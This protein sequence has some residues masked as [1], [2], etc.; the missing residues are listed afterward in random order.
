MSSKISATSSSS[1]LLDPQDIHLGREI[2]RGT[3]GVVLQGTYFGSNVAIKQIASAANALERAQAAKL[4]TNEVKTLSQCRHQNI[5]R[6]VG[7]CVTP[8]ML[9]MDLAS[10][11]TL[12]DLLDR[13]Q[14]EQSS[15]SLTSSLTPLDRLNLVI[16]V[17]NG[18]TMAHSQNILH[19][20]LKP[21]NILIGPDQVPWIADFG[22]AIHMT[23]SVSRGGSS[24]GT[25]GTSQY[26]APELFDDDDDDD[27]D[28]SGSGDGTK[29]SAAALP[30][31]T[32]YQKSADVYSFG[33][34]CW[35]VFTGKVRK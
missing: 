33:M 25:R 20:D 34:L 27:S 24:G 10:N 18:M 2:G 28:D 4:L 31:R 21:A 7:A 6:L 1:W 29:A 8:P 17:C 35:E 15:S 22:F 32:S 12:R 14:E 11:G 30:K 5:V 26:K 19:L 16:G 3:F 9:V 23:A 13:S